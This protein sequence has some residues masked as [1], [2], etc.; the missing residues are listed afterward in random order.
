MNDLLRK[1]AQ[2]F[3]FLLTGTLITITVSAG[4]YVMAAVWLAAGIGMFF[5]LRRF[6]IPILII[7]LLAWVPLFLFRGPQL[8]SAFLV[9]AI[10][11]IL[12]MTFFGPGISL[13][14]AYNSYER[15]R[16]DQNESAAVTEQRRKEEQ[17]VWLDGHNPVSRHSRYRTTKNR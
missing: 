16:A 14:G 6:P 11:V 12:A 8:E 9:L 15:L 13:G 2:I 5:L 1:L 7:S 3:V 10:L 17:S 4:A